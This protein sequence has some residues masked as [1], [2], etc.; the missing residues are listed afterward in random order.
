MHVAQRGRGYTNRVAAPWKGLA[1]ERGDAELQHA[2]SPRDTR[3]TTGR[4]ARFD[5]EGQDDRPRRQEASEGDK[6][7]RARLHG[8]I[9][10][11]AQP[12]ST[13]NANR[14]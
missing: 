4:G 7:E 1:G 5:V 3:V 9:M 11:T 8:D 13:H 14:G 6:V 2:S 10:R 12:S